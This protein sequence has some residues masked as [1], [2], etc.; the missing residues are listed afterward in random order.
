MQTTAVHTIH[1]KVNDEPFETTERDLTPL[2]IMGLAG[3]D[4]QTHYLV[5]VQ[6]NH[7]VS[8]QGRPSESIH[9]HP[10]MSFVVVSVGPTPVSGM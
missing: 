9:L 7:Q 3:Y 4:S 1:F 5:L 6:G 10:H 2:Q 8:Y